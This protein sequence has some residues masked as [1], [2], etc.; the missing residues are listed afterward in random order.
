MSIS[1]TFYDQ[2]FCMKVFGVTFLYFRSALYFFGRIILAQKLLVKC[3]WNRKQ[4]T[5]VT[6]IKPMF[7]LHCPK[8]G[9]IHSKNAWHSFGPFF[10]PCDILLSLIIVYLRCLMLCLI[11]LIRNNFEACSQAWIFPSKNI[12]IRLLKAKKPP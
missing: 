5:N 2:L 6:K 9:V 8:L 12:K 1:P 10:T 11:K 3:W 7:V 4:F